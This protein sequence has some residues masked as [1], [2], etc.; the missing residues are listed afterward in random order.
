LHILAIRLFSLLS[1]LI[2]L[3]IFS[4]FSFHGFIPLYLT[5]ILHLS[6]YDTLTYFHHLFFLISLFMASFPCISL[7]S[8]T[9]DTLTYC[10]HLFS[11]PMQGSWMASSCLVLPKL[12]LISRASISSLMATR[13]DCAPLLSS[14]ITSGTLSS[15]IS[16][17]AL[18]LSHQLLKLSLPFAPLNSSMT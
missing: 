4:H 10:H 16:R 11:F 5:L 14:L 9:Y 8:F 15:L 6:H 7:S 12:L 2:S 13:V 1:C 3:S 17:T 18:R